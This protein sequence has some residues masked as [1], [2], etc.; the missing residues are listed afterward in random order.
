M[1]L[2][3]PHIIAKCGNEVV[4]YAL[5]MH[6]KFANEIELLKP[7]FLEMESLVPKVR[8]FMVMGQVCVAKDFR[9]KRGVQK[10]VPHNAGGY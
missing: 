4:G 10:Y 9:K 8:D 5:C 2:A 7:M 6:P 3:Y 1:H